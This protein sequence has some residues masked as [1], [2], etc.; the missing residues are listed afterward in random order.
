MDLVQIYILASLGKVSQHCGKQK[1]ILAR[2]T[3][4]EP[5]TDLIQIFSKLVDSTGRILI[6]QIYD[7]VSALTDK[8]KELYKNIDFTLE[9]LQQATKSKTN[10]KDTIAETLMARWRYRKLSPA[11]LR[12][13]LIR[14]ASL[15][16]H[17]IEGAFSQGVSD[18]HIF[19]DI[20]Y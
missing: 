5:M 20:S 13:V 8:E 18:R 14:T 6:P 15:S 17:G 16:L 3:I 12:H 10:L 9:E 11:T 1:L 7:Q 4:H 19:E 2:G